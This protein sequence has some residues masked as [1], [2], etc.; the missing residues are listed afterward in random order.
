L[1]SL[2]T[3]TITGSFAQYEVNSPGSFVVVSGGHRRR[4]VSNH[5]RAQLRTDHFS[6]PR[7]AIGLACVCVSVCVG[8]IMFVQMAFDVSVWHG[9]SGSNSKFQVDQSSQSRMQSTYRKRC[10]SEV[11]KSRYDALRKKWRR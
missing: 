7:R 10:K 6:G 9:D 1:H 3:T 8:A 2:A 5:L 4:L 11:G